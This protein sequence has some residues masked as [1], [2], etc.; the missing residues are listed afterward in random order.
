MRLVEVRCVC[1]TSCISL[2]LMYHCYSGSQLCVA[3]SLDGLCRRYFYTTEQ[4]GIPEASIIPLIEY[5][6][7]IRCLQM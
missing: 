3:A 6:T 5:V 7:I 2:L 1:V 4:K